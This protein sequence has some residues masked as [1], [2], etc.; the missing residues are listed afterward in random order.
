MA[1]LNSAFFYC[2]WHPKERKPFFCCLGTLPG[3][4]DGNVER[5]L[6]TIA[7]C[8][9]KLGCLITGGVLGGDAA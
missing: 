1:M 2:P 6:S 9:A 5:R 3:V 7:W 4:L 8:W